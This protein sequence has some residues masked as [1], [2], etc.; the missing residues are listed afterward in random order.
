MLNSSPRKRGS[1]TLFHKSWVLRIRGGRRQGT[2]ANERKLAGP[3]KPVKDEGLSS[4]IAGLDNRCRYAGFSGNRP[5]IHRDASAAGKTRR[6]GARV[7]S[8]VS[9]PSLVSAAVTRRA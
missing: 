3:V 2:N 5:G 8:A 9:T 1:S 7:L 4:V 6:K